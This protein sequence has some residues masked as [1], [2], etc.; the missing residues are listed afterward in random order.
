MIKTLHPCKSSSR[1][2]LN[3]Q[4]WF[5][6]HMHPHVIAPVVFLSYQSW[7]TIVSFL[8]NA[9]GWCSLWFPGA[10]IHACNHSGCHLVTLQ[11]DVATFNVIL[12]PKYGGNSLVT[13]G[14]VPHTTNLAYDDKP[15][16][17]VAKHYC[18]SSMSIV[19]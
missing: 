11:G 9:N 14:S 13:C 10:F 16:R 15:I 2:Q 4:P 3:P 8:N 18:I 17:N 7:N 6:M 19:M 12:A 1:H 5:M